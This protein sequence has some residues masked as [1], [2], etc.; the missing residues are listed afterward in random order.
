MGY[1]IRVLLAPLNNKPKINGKPL[2]GLSSIVSRPFGIM[3]SFVQL[4]G[5][6]DR[7]MFKDIAIR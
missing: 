2:V 1:T 4:V 3:Q 6:A 7:E 5:S